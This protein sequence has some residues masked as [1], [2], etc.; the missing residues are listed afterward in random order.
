MPVIILRGLILLATS[1]IALW[2]GSL[3]LDDMSITW[4]GIITASLIYTVT[5]MLLRPLIGSL[6][7]Q[8]AERG[9]AFVGL[10]VAFLSL[11][12]TDLLSDNL[13]IEGWVTW[14]L[15]TLIVWVAIVVVRMLFG[16][17]FKDRL[18]QG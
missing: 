16:A 10:V 12:V 9:V 6:V 1:A 8:Y 5:M 3:L 15:A 7:R 4:I 13:N 17:A 2:V 14:V 18:A 11:V